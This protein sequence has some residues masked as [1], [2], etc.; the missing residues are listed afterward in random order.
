MSKNVCLADRSAAGLRGLLLIVATV[1]SAAFASPAMGDEKGKRPNI[2]FILGDDLGYGYLGCYGQQKIRT[3]N[4]D[5]LAAEGMRFTQ[6]YAGC[7]VCAPSRSTLMTGLH[8]GHT[9]VRF[10]GGGDPLMPEDVTVAS[11]L[12]QAGYATGCFGKWGLGDI[13]TT[14]VPWKHGFDEFFGYLH[15]VHAHFYYTH[16]LYKN[17]QQFALPGNEGGKQTQYT[18]DVIAEG[19]LDF[20]RQHKDGPFF[21]YVPFT[22]CHTELLVP[23]DSLR[24]Y[25]GKFPETPYIDANRHYADQP[26]PRAALAAMITRMDRDV[27]RISALVKELKLDDNTLIIFSGDNGGQPAG[28]PDLAF[29]QGN[30]VLRGGKG[31]MYE[32]GLRVPGIARWPS[33][34]AAGATSDQVWAFWDMMPTLAEL[35]GTKA[36]AGIDGI[37]IVPTL[38]GPSQAGRE[39]VQHEYFYWEQPAGKSRM[40]AVRMGDWKG[41]R[42]KGDGPIELYDLKTDVSETTNVAEA[43]PEIVARAEKILSQ[44]RTEA[45]TFPQTGKKK[46]DFVK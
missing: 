14:G 8:T 40:Q 19:A 2:I 43:N 5:R 30:G 36:P 18:H 28:G 16:F 42:Q 22:L 32:G 9:P 41:I 39:Q 27:G 38:L 34:V 35:T 25:R 4:I 10:N 46:G 17:D 13:N 45:R 23:E 15:Q 7:T 37:S 21:L 1:I 11:V 24:E 33:K 12:K 29:F 6:C 26:T 44:A 3:P 31:G 20:I